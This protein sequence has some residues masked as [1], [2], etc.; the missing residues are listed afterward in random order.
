MLAVGAMR[1]NPLQ[2]VVSL[3]LSCHQDVGLSHTL[4]AVAPHLCRVYHRGVR[5]EGPGLGGGSGCSL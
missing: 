1:L 3:C 4:L 2:N 5:V